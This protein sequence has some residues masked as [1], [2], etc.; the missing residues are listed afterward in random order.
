[1]PWSE[2][3]PLKLLMTTSYLENAGRQVSHAEGA[4]SRGGEVET[5]T[6]KSPVRVSISVMPRVAVFQSWLLMP[7]TISTR[8]LA[9]FAGLARDWRAGVAA[10][11]A[12]ERTAN[13]RR[14]IVIESACL[15]HIL[16]GNA[17]DV[18]RSGVE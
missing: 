1:M 3:P 4:A 14:E 18:T 6:A 7:S 5:S 8:I 10:S 17:M 2:S 11:V 12:S 9:D 16:L 13:C 15:T